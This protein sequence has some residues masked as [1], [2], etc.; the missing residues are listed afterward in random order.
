MDNAGI[1][2]RLTQ[3]RNLLTGTRPQADPFAPTINAQNG[4]ANWV[5]VDGARYYLPNNVADAEDVPVCVQPE[6][7]FCETRLPLPGR[8]G[9]ADLVPGSAEN[10]VTDRVQQFDSS[11]AVNRSVLTP[12]RSG[13]FAC[14]ADDD[15]FNAFDPYPAG[16]D[17]SGEVGD[18]DL[19]DESG[20]LVLPVERMR[21]VRHAGGRRRQRPG[22]PVEPVG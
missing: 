13:W 19:Y 3:L 7:T 18:S 2:V 12:Q 1:D 21:T 9:E 4:D 6:P 15:N 22:R 16:P 17:R 11:R 14:D 20:S 10:P 8:W 5:L